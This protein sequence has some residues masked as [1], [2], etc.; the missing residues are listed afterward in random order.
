MTVGELYTMLGEMPTDAE[1]FVGATLDSK[2]DGTDGPLF[3]V[4]G[5]F[6]SDTV[7]VLEAFPPDLLREDA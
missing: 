6:A 2:E 3:P 7:V 1:V 4:D 5:L